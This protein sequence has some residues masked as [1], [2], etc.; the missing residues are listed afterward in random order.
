MFDIINILKATFYLANQYMRIA[1]IGQKGMPAIHGGVER[2]VHDLALHLAKNGHDVTVYARGW[3]TGIKKDQ[4]LN[5]V[6]VKYLPSIHT[7]HLD[8]ISHTFLA[9]LDAIKNKYDVIHYHG[10][11][12]SLLSWLPRLFARQTLVIS[13]FHSID[14]YHKKWNQLAKII[15]RIGEW[16]ACNFPHQTITISQGLEQY[17][18]NEFDKKTIYIP[19]G[20]NAQAE[21]HLGSNLIKKFGLKKE[22][23]LLT[24]SR[25]IEH[26]GI[27]ILIQAFLNLKNKYPKKLSP[28]KLA[29]VG[30]SAY[31]DKYIKK[32][33][34]LA[35]ISPDII[36]TGFQAGQTLEE[37]YANALVLI[38]PSFNEGLPLT[39][40]QAMSFGKPVMVSN[41]PEHLELISDN[42]FLFKSDNIRDL[43][44]KILSF[45][46]ID[47]E[48]IK[49]AGQKNKLL[50]E[51]D[52]NWEKLVLEIE[53]VYQM[54]NI[55]EKSWKKEMKVAV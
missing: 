9:T 36:F 17:C 13:T 12:P 55:K 44:K 34:E 2:H 6:L 50:V 51:Q 16:S 5:G 26:K 47:S 8:A 15:L 20:V 28:L 1:M 42:E 40:L 14:R 43:E 38:H 54:K 31:T 37:L 21:K 53:K 30:G 46:D 49:E 7:K 24:V 3:Y 35:S 33:H 4:N 18:L 27:H 29:I 10:I 45:L 41:I 22:K 19:N 39:V 11:G 48:K 23:Y 52:Y 32:L 25:L